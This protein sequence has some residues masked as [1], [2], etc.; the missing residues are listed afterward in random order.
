MGKLHVMLEDTI[1]IVGTTNLTMYGR[2]TMYKPYYWITSNIFTTPRRPS[3][4]CRRLVK[5][6]HGHL[7]KGWSVKPFKLV[8]ILNIIWNIY[9]ISIKYLWNIYEIS[10]TYLWNIYDISMKYPWIFMNYLFNI[11]EYLRNHWTP[12]MGYIYRFYFI[13]VNIFEYTWSTERN[14]YNVQWTSMNSNVS[15]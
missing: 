9:E 12:T 5:A 7:L 15:E 10:M 13:V 1:Y 6:L 4:A 14:I 8:D 11:M 2:L 3:A